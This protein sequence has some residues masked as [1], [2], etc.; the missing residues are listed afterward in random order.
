MD[1]RNFIKRT[2][3]ASGGLFFVPQ[4]VKAFEQQAQQL[5]GNKKNSNS[6]IERRK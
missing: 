1:R 5:F 3:L 4:F 2:S 6:S